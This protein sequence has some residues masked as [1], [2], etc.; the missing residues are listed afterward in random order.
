MPAIVRPET[1]LSFMAA[2]T[3]SPR[4][5]S[6]A[7]GFDAARAIPRAR[8]S[9]EYFMVAVTSQNYGYRLAGRLVEHE[10]DPTAIVLLQQRLLWHGVELGLT[11]VEARLEGLRHI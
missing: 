6:A 7:A 5:M 3:R 10:C 8:T 2:M 9:A 11:I 4:R 1:V